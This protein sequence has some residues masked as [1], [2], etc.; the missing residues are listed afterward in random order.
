MT[1]TNLYPLD[2]NYHTIEIVTNVVPLITNSEKYKIIQNR[3]P[4]TY[5]QGYHPKA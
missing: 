5:C 1:K 3:I 4:N 2:A